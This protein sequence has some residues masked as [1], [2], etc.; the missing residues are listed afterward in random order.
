MSFNINEKSHTIA[1]KGYLVNLSRQ[2]RNIN[3]SFDYLPNFVLQLAA[4]HAVKW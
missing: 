2:E 1:S 3:K 4:Q